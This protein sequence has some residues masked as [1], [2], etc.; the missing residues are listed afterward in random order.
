MN[1]N[2]TTDIKIAL[3][4]LEQSS[5]ITAEASRKN[6]ESH[7]ALN[8]QLVE[9]IGTIKSSHSKYDLMIE[10]SVTTANTISETLNKHIEY[11]RPILLRNKRFQDNTDAM[12]RGIFSKTGFVVIGIITLAVLSYLGITPANLNGK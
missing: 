7:T 12:V 2:D 6:T 5:I 4:K 1:N 10:G 11:S 3:A 9:L 8:I